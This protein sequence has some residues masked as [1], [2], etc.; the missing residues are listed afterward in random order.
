MG[1]FSMVGSAEK[2]VMKRIIADLPDNPQGQVSNKHEIKEVIKQTQSSM[3]PQIC[4][5]FPQLPRTFSDVFSKSEW[6]IGKSDF[7]QH[8]IDL[9]LGSKPVYLPFRRR[10]LHF[11]K[12]LRQKIDKLFEH[13]LIT[14][15]HSPYNSA[16][17][18][19]TEEMVNSG[20]SST[21]DN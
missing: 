20:W 8:K 9:Y 6:D 18:L 5:Q 15:C 7:V 2:A 10:R 12:D 21:I 19:F 3:E 17:M 16:A 4:P 11:K 13:K 1:S 14:P